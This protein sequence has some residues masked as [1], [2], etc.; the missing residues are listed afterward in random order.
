[1]KNEFYFMVA[2]IFAVVVAG[3]VLSNKMKRRSK[4]KHSIIS[5][6]NHLID[7]Y[8]SIYENVADQFNQKIERAEKYNDQDCLKRLQKLYDDTVRIAE[9]VEKKLDSL[10]TSIVD[11]KFNGT[12]FDV[13]F[14][15]LKVVESYIA[16]LAN[17]ATLI[18]SIHPVNRGSSSG[19]EYESFT[20]YTEPKNKKP[21]KSSRF[22][23]SC[24][25][26]KDLIKKYRELAK[27]YHPDNTT[28][29]NTESFKSLK[30]E[31]DEYIIQ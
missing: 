10:N 30:A 18:R 2:I 14:N 5:W 4:D 15:D 21:W 28:T 3:F 31:Y 17:I 26:K 29:G 22:F 7:Q 16:E 9:N 6:Y 19:Y 12:P 1:M 8:V 20:S 27:I 23:A 11:K 13:L 25:L 24:N